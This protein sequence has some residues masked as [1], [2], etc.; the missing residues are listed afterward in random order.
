[1][2]SP[3]PAACLPEADA[4]ADAPVFPEEELGKSAAVWSLLALMT[5]GDILAAPLITVAP[6]PGP[7]SLDGVPA[8]AGVFVELGD[9]T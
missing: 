2:P 5:G 9:W 6:T 7:L 8:L 4:A 3:T 1:M